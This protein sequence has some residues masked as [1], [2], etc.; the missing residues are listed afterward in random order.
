MQTLKECLDK[1]KKEGYAIGHFNISTAD[2]MRAFAEMS[3]EL[4]VPIMIGTSEGEAKFL[5]INQVVGMAR[6]WQAMGRPVFLNAD[7]YKSFE[8]VKE[9]I[10]VGYDTVLID[11]SKLPYEENVALTKK[12]VDYANEASVKSGREIMV[13]GELGYLRGESQIQEKVEISHDDYTKPEQAADF[14]TR[15]GISRLAIV[16]GNIHGIVKEVV[17]APTPGDGVTTETSGEEHLDIETLKSIAAAVPQVHLVLH[18]GSGLASGEI[19]EAITNG[20]SNIHINTELRVAY[21][22]AL[23]EAIAREP[24]QTAPY[25]LMTAGYEASKN[26]AREKILLFLN[27]KTPR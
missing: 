6:S 18:G 17:T 8:A 12:V 16:F 25:K 23:K 15:T 3:A 13:E 4:N 19:T 7:H 9:A 5:G 2:Q 24:N 22:S 11:G 1:A 14:V 27:G 10:D 20:I 26:L 21:T